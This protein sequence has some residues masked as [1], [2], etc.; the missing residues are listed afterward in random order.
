MS[1]TRAEAQLEGAHH[2]IESLRSDIRKLKVEMDAATER[3]S[4]GHLKGD[5][6]DGAHTPHSGDIN[7]RCQ[8]DCLPDYCRSCTEIAAARLQERADADQRISVINKL[9]DELV[10]SAYQRGLSDGECL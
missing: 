1:D 7:H 2:L 3:M 8:S 4:C 10:K 6:V 5:L 9:N